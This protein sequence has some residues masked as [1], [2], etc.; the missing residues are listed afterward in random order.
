M[1]KIQEDSITTLTIKIDKTMKKAFLHFCKT[2]DT[3]ASK[4]IRGMIRVHIAEH[5]DKIFQ[6]SMKNKMIRDN[7]LEELEEL[8][9][10]SK[11]NLR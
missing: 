10:N 11:F 1:K 6:M 5:R 2:N 4:F 8:E 9:N 7:R 3:D